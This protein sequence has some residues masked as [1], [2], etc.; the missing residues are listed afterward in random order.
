V[1]V[2]YTITLSVSRT[3]GSTTTGTGAN[4]VTT[5]YW[6]ETQKTTLTISGDNIGSLAKQYPITIYISKNGSTEY[7]YSYTISKDCAHTQEWT[8]SDMSTIINT[9]GKR[10]YGLGLSAEAADNQ[11]NEGEYEISGSSGSIQLSL[12][13]EIL[14]P[15]TKK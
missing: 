2:N 4:S 1:R 15:S 12:N 6:Q 7:N 14:E 5:F 9:L 10:K 13:K 11:S 3:S 8:E